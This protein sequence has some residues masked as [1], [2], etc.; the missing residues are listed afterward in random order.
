V[1]WP[2]SRP[3]PGGVAA[4]TLAAAAGRGPDRPVRVL[5][6]VWRN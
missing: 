6:G 1:V 3:D 5:Y 4:V 2:S